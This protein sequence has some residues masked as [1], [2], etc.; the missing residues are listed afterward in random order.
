MTN[1]ILHDESGQSYES[2]QHI[3]ETTP[4]N[5]YRAVTIK[6]AE[7][8]T[9]R[10]ISYRAMLTEPKTY[11]KPASIDGYMQNEYIRFL[12]NMRFNEQI[13]VIIYTSLS[14]GDATKE[15]G[16]N[17][18]GIIRGINTTGLIRGIHYDRLVSKN[19]PNADMKLAEILRE[20]KKNY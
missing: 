15:F 5:V 4:M 18:A 2:E 8:L 9:T 11:K 17:N 20:F 16:L 13:P 7:T 10:I 3:C 6:D 12:K 14:E 1:I 19:D